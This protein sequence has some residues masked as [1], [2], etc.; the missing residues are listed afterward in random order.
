MKFEKVKNENYCGTVV[1]LDQFVPIPKAD[2]IQSALIFGNSVIISKDATVGDIGVFF[3]VECQLSAEFVA[4]N[5]LYRKPEYGNIDATKTGYFETHRRIKCAK[6]LGVKSEGLWLPISA[7]EYLNLKLSDFHEGDTFDKIGT[8][9]ICEKYIPKHN[10]NAGPRIKGKH[11]RL[12]DSIVSG[13]FRFHFD[14]ENLRKNIHKL[15][16]T[17]T[18]SISDKWHGTSAIFGKPLVLRN[19]RWFERILRKIGVPIQETVHG[20]TYSSRKM[21]KAV[22]GVDKANGIHYYGEDIWGVVAKEVSNKIPN[23]Y[24]IYGEIVGYT[25]TGSHIQAASGGRSYHYGCEVGQHKLMVYRVITTNIDGKTIEL[26]WPQLGEFCNKYGFERV[27]EL[28]YGKITDIVPWDAS[29]D[30]RDWQNNVLKYLEVNFVHDQMC[31]YNDNKIPAEGI[32]VRVDQL[33]ECRSFKL[34]NFKF[35]EDETKLN[36]AGVVDIETIESD[37]EES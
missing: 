16:V 23:S 5:N 24:T 29:M 32:V 12:E 17:D 30:M 26:S 31:P 22:N 8:H 27:K 25:P 19:L 6:F 20:L 1:K 13:Q 34:K 9:E 37:V 2:K 28:F 10:S 14:T 33:E 21:V 18:I 36:D 7:F 4:S 35:L 3:P 11:V 15:R